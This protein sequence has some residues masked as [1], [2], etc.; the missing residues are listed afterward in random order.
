MKIVI[1]E[2]S[3]FCFGV[4]RAIATLEEELAQKPIVYCVGDI[5]HN[6]REIERL[7]TKGL[8]I[9][10]SGELATL[11]NSAVLFRAHGEPPISYSHVENN[12]LQLTDATCPVVLQLQKKIRQT[13]EEMKPTGGQVVLF[14][15]KGHAE[16]IGLMGQTNNECILIENE[17]QIAAIDPTKSTAIFAQTTKDPQQYADLIKAIK[18]VA[19]NN[20][21]AHNTICKQMADRAKRLKQFA[22]EH[23]MILFVGGAKSSNSKVLFDICRSINANSFFVTNENEVDPKWFDHLPQSVGIFGAT[24]TPLWLME[25]VKIAV[26]KISAN[27]EQQ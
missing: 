27:A 17:T 11:H 5:V 1:D 13:W 4:K 6:E 21:V 25:S 26:E 24:S 20:V 2:G 18:A 8:K 10:S 12:N 19:K 14:G 3:G 7:Q 15:K 23:E 22:G 16:V 9:I